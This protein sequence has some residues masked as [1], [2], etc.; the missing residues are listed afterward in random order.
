[1]QTGKLPTPNNSMGVVSLTRKGNNLVF[2]PWKL[3]LFLKNFS[4]RLGKQLSND[5]A[6]YVE[7]RKMNIQPVKKVNCIIDFLF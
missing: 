4:G 3:I 7:V 6:F 5:E 1:M 2:V